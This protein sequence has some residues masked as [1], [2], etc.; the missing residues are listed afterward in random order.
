VR[1]RSRFAGLADRRSITVVLGAFALAHAPAFVA[2]RFLHVA[3]LGTS[4]WAR[5]DTNHYRDVAVSGYDLVHCV[6]PVTGPTVD[7]CGSSGWFPGYPYLARLIPGVR[8]DLAMLVVARVSLLVLLAVLWFA[9]LR[10]RPFNESLPLMAIAS[11][12]PGSIYFIALFP[13]SLAVLGLMAMVVGLDRK[14]SA[15][16]VVAAACAAFTYPV[17]ALGGLGASL[18]L[19]ALDTAARRWSIRSV[20]P[21]IGSGIGAVAAFAVMRAQTGRWN[22][23]FT[24]QA[25]YRHE[26]GL[27]FVNIFKR[28]KG[29][30]DPTDSGGVAAGAQSS[31]PSCVAVGPRTDRNGPLWEWF[32]RCISP[33]TSMA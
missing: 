6:D 20:L 31:C 26:R 21:A 15:I 10:R 4:E 16:V 29:V 7:W 24:V 23:F 25:S 2:A 9:F 22:A 18:A 33:L 17:A 14:R 30:I 5:W 13:M 12:F 1:N 11:L 32:A 28:I 27:P 19:I 3:F 8:I